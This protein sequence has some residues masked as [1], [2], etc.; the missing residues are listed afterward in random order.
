MTPLTTQC[1]ARRFRLE[2]GFVPLFLVAVR[3]SLIFF[4]PSLCIFNEGLRNRDT[5]VLESAKEFK[6][7]FP[8]YPP[9]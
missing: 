5:A 6:L 4:M 1:H 3:A 7:V 9:P 2:S 8:G